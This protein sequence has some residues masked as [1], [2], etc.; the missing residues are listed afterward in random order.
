MKIK[1]ERNGT[2]D[3]FLNAILTF[4]S[5][6]DPQKAQ[7]YAENYDNPTATSYQDVEYPGRVIRARGW[8]DNQ[9]QCLDKR[10]FRAFG[11]W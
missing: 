6:I 10:V 9:K 5:T 8:N 2:Y 7:Y 11:H 4:E 1:N 3:D